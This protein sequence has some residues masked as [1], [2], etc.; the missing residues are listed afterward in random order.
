[1]EPEKQVGTASKWFRSLQNAAAG[2][3]SS[4]QEAFTKIDITPRKERR[5]FVLE[6]EINRGSY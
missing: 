2:V 6:D 4:R 3:K 1:M 5:L